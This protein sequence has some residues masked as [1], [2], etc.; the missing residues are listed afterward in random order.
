MMPSNER[1]RHSSPLFCHFLSFFLFF[2]NLAMSVWIVAGSAFQKEYS[3][4][5]WT[6][7]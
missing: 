4:S 3:S 2:Y 1:W 7:I 6:K 5:D